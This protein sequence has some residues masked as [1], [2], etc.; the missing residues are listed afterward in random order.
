VDFY[1]DD[2]EA[3]AAEIICHEKREEVAEDRAVRWMEDNPKGIAGDG[4][5]TSSGVLSTIMSALQSVDEQGKQLADQK[6][7]RTEEEA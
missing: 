1:P 5:K 3:I 2:F 6:Q 4:S 7:D